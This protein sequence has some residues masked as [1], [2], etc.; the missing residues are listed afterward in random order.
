V[1]ILSSCGNDDI[2]TEGSNKDGQIQDE[3]S[4]GGLSD[5]DPD[6]SVTDVDPDQSVTDEDEV[7]KIAYE[8]PEDFS[9]FEAYK[10]DFL[11]G[12]IY[13]DAARSE[14]KDLILKHFNVITPEN[15]MKPQY[16]QPKEGN[17][18]YKESDIMI[19]F[20][21][22]NDIS[23][24]GH[25][26]AWHQQSGR[27]M[28][29]NV[30]V[31]QEAIEQLKSHI[32]NVAGNYKGRIIAWDVVNEAINDG[33]TLPKD[34]DWTKCLRQT[35][36][37]NSIGPDYL[38]MAFT[39]AREADPD[40]KLYY[41][42]YNLNNK[43]K[44]DIV[45]AMVKDFQVQG[46]PIDGIGMQ[47]HY[48]V[49]TSVGTVEYS[50]NRFSEL[51]VEV[52]ITELDI[53]VNGAAPTGLTK[54]QEIAQANKYAE[55]FILLKDYSDIIERVTFW[56]YTDHKSW[57]SD[58]FPCLFNKDNSP[59]EA[60][61]AV[62]EPEMYLFLNKTDSVL[63]PGIAKAKYGTPTIDAEV[64]DIWNSAEAVNVDKSITAW[65]G[66]KGTVKH[67]WD[68]KYV[69]ALFEVSDTLLNRDSNN[70]Y[71]QDSVE[72]FL[73]QYN[74]KTAYYDIDDG[75]YRVNYEGNSSFGSK[76]DTP[77]FTAKAKK[78]GDGYIVEMAIPLLEEP[79]E[80]TVMGFDAQINDSNEF[81]VRQSIAKFNDP[82]D[83]S[84]Q[85]T[86]LWGELLLEK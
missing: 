27:W 8:W 59:K 77:G 19:S 7:D 20:A 26:L 38:A 23:V 4:V 17:F 41:N 1:T 73:D 14:D 61:Y 85:S 52:S 36:W 50:L 74:D 25:T 12:T 43:S 60:V 78:T 34:G 71:E 56:G 58:R 83:N 75:Q 22:E 70:D 76:P 24:V 42:D 28:G 32:M 9:L 44:A 86:E 29:V 51:G 53:G 37:L 48:D 47:G 63:E 57:R 49:D 6:Q 40:A 55:L 31:R 39:F 2:S 18:N 69:Y 3:D 66:A 35:Q 82:T 5:E 65:E 72:I 13:T 62:L 80:G 68:E 79:K 30:G 16:M 11:I 84:W 33:V 46:I 67:L 64:D 15:L 45:Y 21:E 81:G 10:D 54:E